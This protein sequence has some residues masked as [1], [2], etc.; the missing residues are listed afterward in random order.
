MTYS[1]CDGSKKLVN[2]SKYGG[3]GNACCFHQQMETKTVSD[4]VEEH[5]I[6]SVI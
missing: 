2:P 4:F 6:L 3:L 5:L 1:I